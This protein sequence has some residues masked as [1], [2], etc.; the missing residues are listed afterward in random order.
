MT[1]REEKVREQSFVR[2]RN[3]V[4]IK[5]EVVVATARCYV[6]GDHDLDR[7]KEV[8]RDL[9]L[10]ERALSDALRGGAG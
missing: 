6:R 5:L 9:E 2:L 3:L 7:L 4:Q 8:I 1:K 10:A